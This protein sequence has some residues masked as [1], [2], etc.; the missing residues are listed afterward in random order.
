MSTVKQGFQ[1]FSVSSFILVEQRVVQG[2]E[3]VELVNN[4]LN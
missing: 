2:E 3:L 1:P 4:S